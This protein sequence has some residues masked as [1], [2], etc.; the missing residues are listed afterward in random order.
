MA[1]RT[2]IFT[3]DNGAG[4]SVDAEI[5]KQLLSPLGHE[6]QV[7][8]EQS[9]APANQPDCTIY[10][11][12][13]DFRFAGRCNVL[14][15]N[16]EWFDHRFVGELNQLDCIACKTHEG[17]RVMSG[18]PGAKTMYLGWTTVDRYKPTV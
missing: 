6:I 16:P 9:D 3:R 13:M 8:L 15:P 12:R 17:L 2:I 14:I 1:I 5:L 4:L 7:L 18:L 10:L 11:E